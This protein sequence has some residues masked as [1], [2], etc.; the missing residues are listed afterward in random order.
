MSLTTK[1]LLGASIGLVVLALSARDWRKSVAVVF[2]LLLFEGAIR[3]WVI[4]SAAELIYFAKDGVLLG[5]YI[6][7]LTS[8]RISL[9][10]L[11]PRLQIRPL[12]FLSA[13]ISLSAF[14]PN[15]GWLPAAALGIKNYLFYIPL[16]ILVPQ[17]FRNRQDLVQRLSF[18]MLLSFPI[19]L[20]G[21]AQFRSDRFSVVNRY[22]TSENQETGAVS[23]FGTS[24]KVRITGTFAY[25][26]GHTTFV[27]YFFAVTIALL[28]MDNVP[29]RL[30]HSY[31]TLPMLVVNAFMGGSRA[32]VVT[33][34]FIVIGMVFATGAFASWIIRRRVVGLL[35]V[36]VVGGTVVQL[37]FREAA[38]NSFDRLQYAGD[39]FYMRT[40]GVLQH[41]LTDAWEK[42][43]VVGFGIGTTSPSVTALIGRL[44]GQPPTQ[45]PPTYDNEVSQVFI[46]LGLLGFI[47]W[48]LIRFWALLTSWFAFRHCQDSQLK[49]LLLA[50]TLVSIPF[51][52]MSVV[53]N[54]VAGV[55]LWGAMGIAMMPYLNPQVLRSMPASIQSHRRYSSRN[56]STP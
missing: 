56:H 29:F 54:H 55:L 27:C 8:P 22:S 11:F 10:Q 35:G 43:G 45:S 40:I 9:E 14:N 23:T 47:A 48:Y 46:E 6:G 42:G 2:V 34:A 24:D 30:W 51:F 53:L 49:P 28:F 52:L 16:M 15:I 17:M 21:V 50:L 26:T 39:S 41:G 4:P 25:L 44:H 5:A 38:T 1:L 31:V 13:A 20:L 36:L 33:M 32:S 19:C 37:F 7:Y 18:Y 3:K 12:I